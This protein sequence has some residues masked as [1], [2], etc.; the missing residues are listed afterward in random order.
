MALD[1][2]LL[3][4]VKDIVYIR[5]SQTLF[6]THGWPHVENV[7]A[8]CEQLA[9]LESEDP[10]VCGIAAYCHD[11]GR[12]KEEKRRFI[13]RIL[14]KKDHAA[15]SIKPTKNILV[16]IGIKTSEAQ[17]ILEAVRVH[18]DKFYFGNNNIARILR[19]ADKADGFGPW[20][21]KNGWI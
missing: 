4:R 9:R 8:Y 19:D 6:W 10:V 18:S 7:E 14:G 13:Y 2:R 5:Y 20:G 11:L 1:T 16:E 17:I 12:L 21:F 15:Y 3:K